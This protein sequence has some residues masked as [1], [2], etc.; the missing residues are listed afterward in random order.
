M[1]GKTVQSILLNILANEQRSLSM[2]CRVVLE[3]GVTVYDVE[4]PDEA[5]RITIAKTGKMLNPDLSFVEINPG[6]RA[7]PH[8]GDTLEAAFV[9]ASDALV[10]LELTMD[11]FNVD[12]EEHATRIARSEIGQQLEEVPLT[13]L[14]TEVLENAE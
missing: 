5:I 12:G 2:D 10:A 9:S 1:F 6:S 7:C 3:A 11:V 13:V 14:E 4:T 8:C